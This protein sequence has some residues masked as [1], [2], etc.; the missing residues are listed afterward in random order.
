[1]F[2]K[3]SCNHSFTFSSQLKWPSTDWDRKTQFGRI[4]QPNNSQSSRKSFTSASISRERGES[5]LLPRSSWTRHRLRYGF[6]TAGWSRRSERRRD[7]RLLRPPCLKTSRI[8]LIT[9]LQ[10]LQELLQVRI[11]N[12]GQKLWVHWTTDSK[13]IAK[14]INLSIPKCARKTFSCSFIIE[15]FVFRTL[16][17]R[18]EVKET[19]S[20][21]MDILH[22]L[23][24]LNF[25]NSLETFVC[26]IQGISTM[27]IN[28]MHFHTVYKSL[29]EPNWIYREPRLCFQNMYWCFC[30]VYDDWFDVHISYICVLWIVAYEGFRT[31]CTMRLQGRPLLN[32]STIMC[33]WF[34][35]N[36]HCDIPL[37]VNLQREIINTVFHSVC[38]KKDNAGCL[39]VLFFIKTFT[40]FDFFSLV[41]LCAD[42]LSFISYC[43]HD[44]F[45]NL[46]VSIKCLC[47]FFI[48]LK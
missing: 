27:M 9:Q 36:V 30:C 16:N 13:Y 31:P 21:T 26:V 24:E 8:T 5:K 17:V 25:Q 4:S 44:S 20:T 11:H 47:Q 18:R 43:L 38:R 12:R 6:R 15:Q 37:A 35:L 14:S 41:F 28:I 1:M 2:D 33:E 39:N 48:Y 46:N 19:F 45:R 29:N 32:T 42:E 7:S 40:E 3:Q 34:P 22:R 10:H 23:L